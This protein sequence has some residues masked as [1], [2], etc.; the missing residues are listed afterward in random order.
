[1]TWDTSRPRDTSRLSELDDLQR[2]DKSTFDEWAQTF[3]WW[4]DSTQSAGFVRPSSSTTQA[5][6]RAFYG[7]RSQVS[8]PGRDGHMM[9]VS[10]ESRLLVFHSNRS[11]IVGGSRMMLWNPSG[12]GIPASWSVWISSGSSVINAAEGEHRIPFG[13]EFARAPRV[14]V[15]AVSGEP[16]SYLSYVVSVSSRVDAI[17]TS[18]FSASVDYVGPGTDPED[19]VVHW[20]ASGLT[21]HWL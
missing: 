5:V 10:D 9:V 11:T 19:C 16:A 8:Y 4:G 17:N 21:V 18:Q 2:S 13:V 12:G 1:M 7:S 20:I 15:T 14:F 6:H 3:V